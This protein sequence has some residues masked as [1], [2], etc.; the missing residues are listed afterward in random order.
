[1]REKFKLNQFLKQNCR[2]F[3]LIHLCLKMLVLFKFLQKRYLTDC[4]V[5]FSADLIQKPLH[6]IYIFEISCEHFIDSELLF[7]YRCSVL[8]ENLKFNLLKSILGIENPGFC[9]ENKQNSASLLFHF[10]ESYLCSF[11]VILFMRNNIKLV[12]FECE[13]F[14]FYLSFTFANF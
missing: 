7:H 8:F 13:L 14:Q 4:A 5:I 3:R 10:L 9:F 1:M 11:Y 6:V 2:F 12:L